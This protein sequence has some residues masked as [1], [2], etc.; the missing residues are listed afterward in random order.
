MG[1]KIQ[2]VGNWF[3]R[4]FSSSER[5]DEAAEREE[6]GIPDR[7]EEELEREGFPSFAGTEGAEAAEEELTEFEPPRDPAP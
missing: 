3:R 6:Y 1:P 4:L 5:G 2:L 7:E